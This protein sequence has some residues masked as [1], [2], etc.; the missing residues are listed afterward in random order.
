[1]KVKKEDLVQYKFAKIIN[2]KENATMLNYGFLDGGFYMAADI[3]PNTRYFERQN[4]NMV[5]YDKL[6]KREISEKKFDYIVVMNYN[7]ENG[8]EY[9]MKNYELVTQEIQEYENDNYYFLL[10]KLKV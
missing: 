1:M 2:E 7:N 6:I 9:I 5:D 10:Y 4:G 3:L 8:P